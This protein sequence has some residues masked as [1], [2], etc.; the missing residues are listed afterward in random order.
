MGDV[1]PNTLVNLCHHLIDEVG[2]II[3]YDLTIREAELTTK[4]VTNLRD[5][6]N[7]NY[8]LNLTPNRRDKPLKRFRS[9]IEFHSENLKKQIQNLMEFSAS[10]LVAKRCS[11]EGFGVSFNPSNIGLNLTP[12]GLSNQTPQ[13]R[14]LLT[15][16]DISMQKSSSRLLSFMGLRYLN[17]HDPTLFQSL[18]LRYLKRTWIKESLEKQ[19]F[20]MAHNIR[21]TYRHRKDRLNLV[22][23]CGQTNLFEKG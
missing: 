3:Y 8:W 18:R 2:Q 9:L 22:D 19:I 10:Q 16:I 14:C 1:N 12:E 17:D 13:R 15:N 6:W 20:E 4:Q 5:Y 21:D 11:R 7:L 23:E